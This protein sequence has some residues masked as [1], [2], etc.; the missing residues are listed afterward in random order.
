MH[1]F[2]KIKNNNINMNQSKWGH[3]WNK[4]C[5]DAETFIVFDC[6]KSLE[7]TRACVGIKL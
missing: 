5:C 2:F 3:F 4:S 6:W 1:Y 7:W